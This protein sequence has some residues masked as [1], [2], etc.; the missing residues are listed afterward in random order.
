MLSVTRYHIFAIIPHYFSTLDNAIFIFHDGK[1]PVWKRPCTHFNFSA[2]FISF[3]TSPSAS[4][5][6]EV[7]S[8][9]SST[10]YQT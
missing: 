4:L 8:T 7:L 10:F 5:S 6:Q 1:V 3:A 2:N 9:G